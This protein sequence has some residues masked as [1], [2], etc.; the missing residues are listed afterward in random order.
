MAAWSKLFG[1][2]AMSD[3]M[4]RSEITIGLRFRDAAVIRAD[5][6]DNLAHLT[7][8]A[9]ALLAAQAIFIVVV[10]WGTEHGWPR[11]MALISILLLVIAALLVLTLLRSIYM[12]APRTDDTATYAYEDIL[13]VARVLASRGARFNA[14]LYMTFLSVIL[15]GVGAVDVA[16]GLA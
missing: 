13:A 6:S 12:P 3:D 2:G 15:L 8:K 1:F 9:G 16:L 11:V 14:A 5:V 7:Q 4:L 10:T